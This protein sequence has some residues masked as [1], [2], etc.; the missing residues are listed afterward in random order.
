MTD[1]G[2]SCDACLASNVGSR[3]LTFDL[4]PKDIKILD[5]GGTTHKPFHA[6][7]RMTAILRNN[8]TKLHNYTGPQ[9]EKNKQQKRIETLVSRQQEILPGTTVRMCGPDMIAHDQFGAR[10][11]A[12]AF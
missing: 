12:W 5:P 11:A 1:K 10:E 6:I 9:R 8:Y 3:P 2:L 4:H 7:L